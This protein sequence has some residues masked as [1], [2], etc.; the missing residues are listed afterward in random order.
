MQSLVEVIA[1]A[2]PD[3]YGS[4]APSRIRTCTALGLNELPP[5]VGLLARIENVGPPSPAGFGATAFATLRT[6]LPSRSAR[7][8]AKAGARTTE[9]NLGPSAYKAAALPV[10]LYGRIKDTK[11]PRRRCRIAR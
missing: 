10:E 5:A 2:T 9:S 8:A 6:G 11:R 4:G 7:S 3:A 1:L